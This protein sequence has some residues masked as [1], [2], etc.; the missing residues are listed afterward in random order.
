MMDINFDPDYIIIFITDYVKG[1]DFPKS[2][3][4]LRLKEDE[5]HVSLIK[6]PDDLGR[7][8]REKIYQI[9]R[10][11]AESFSKNPP[12]L[13]GQFLGVEDKERGK[14][15][16][17]GKLDFPDLKTWQNAVRQFAPNVDFPI[18]HIT[19]YF[20][21]YDENGYSGIALNGQERF[22]ELTFD[23]PIK[24][25]RMLQNVIEYNKGE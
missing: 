21:K 17:I 14:R 6:F 16:I 1:F 9:T 7:E 15:T 12:K 3:D 10:D 4:G 20:D 8:S 23:L 25:E 5:F 11:H 18:P 2:I 22:D 24:T 19:I 13:K